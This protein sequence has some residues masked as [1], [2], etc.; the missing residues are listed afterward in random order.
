MGERG[1]VFTQAPFYFGF[2]M[3]PPKNSKPIEF[4]HLKNYDFG[5][6]KYK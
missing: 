5:T 4:A 2:G 6:C 1:V 3:C